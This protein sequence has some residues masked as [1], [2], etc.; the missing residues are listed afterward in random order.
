MRDGLN[1]KELGWWACRLGAAALALFALLAVV[2]GSWLY[3][4]ILT[5]AS[6]VLLLMAARAQSGGARSLPVGPAEQCRATP[7]PE[8]ERLE[9]A[10]MVEEVT[11]LSTP[12]FREFVA[13]AWRR[14][15]YAVTQPPPE[16]PGEADDL[17]LERDQSRVV[18]RICLQPATV[19]SVAALVETAR[20]AGLAS[21]FLVVRDEPSEAVVRACHGGGVQ[22][23]GALRLASL[24]RQARAAGAG[25]AATGKGGHQG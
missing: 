8:E 12:E 16:W 3:A 23:V 19:E 15:G 11:R 21:A 2:G 5:V 9:R 20:E 10:S 22:V 17:L 14:V 18:A 25:E 4:G 1:Q 24:V 13:R 6:G 7:E